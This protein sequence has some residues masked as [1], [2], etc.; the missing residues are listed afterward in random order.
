[1]LESKSAASILVKG[2]RAG[3]DTKVRSCPTTDVFPSLLDTFAWVAGSDPSVQTLKLAAFVP[4]P[5]GSISPV[6]GFAPMNAAE[7]NYYGLLP[8]ALQNAAGKF[9]LPTTKS[10]DAAVA[11][12]TENANGTLSPNFRDKNPAAYPLP[13]IWYAV[14]PT[15]NLSA[16]AAQADRTLLGD[17]L[18]L[19]G[20]SQTSDLPTG[21]VPLPKSLDRVAAA[22]LSRDVVATPPTTTTTIPPPTTTTLAPVTTTTRPKV[23][24]TTEPKVTGSTTPKAP[25]TTIAF[26]STAFRVT[27]KSDSWMAP[28]F[29]SVVAGAMLCGPGL[30]LKTRR[31]A[32]R[33]I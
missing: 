13:Q 15:S 7:A 21:F 17:L 3:G 6:A 26:H 24:A 19:S 28:A 2:L 25:P 29:V 20:G 12:A 1:V 27:G 9:V 31:R 10:L 5:N 18:K 23:T 30:L 8:A 33:V 32:G 11:G 14:V 16:T 4:P 22:D